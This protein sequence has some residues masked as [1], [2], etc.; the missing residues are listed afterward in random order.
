MIQNQSYLKQLL[1]KIVLV[2]FPK[3]S[4]R[5]FAEIRKEYFSLPLHLV[6]HVN[7]FLLGWRDPERVESAHQVLQ[8]ERFPTS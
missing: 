3:F 7:N 5:E 4:Q 8:E 6:L 2:K 1:P